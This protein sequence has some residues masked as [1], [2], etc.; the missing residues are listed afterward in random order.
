M[1]GM[2]VMGKTRM[3]LPFPICPSFT[4]PLSKPWRPIINGV[5]GRP[6]QRTSLGGKEQLQLNRLTD[7]STLLPRKIMT[8][9]IIDDVI[10]LGSIPAPSSFYGSFAYSAHIEKNP[11]DHSRITCHP[12]RLTQKATVIKR[13]TFK[14]ATSP[15]TKASRLSPAEDCGDVIHEGAFIRRPIDTRWAPTTTRWTTR[16]NRKNNPEAPGSG[17]EHSPLPLALSKAPFS[18]F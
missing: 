1:A 12:L 5:V 11:T 17:K 8:D 10:E 13:V 15:V 3:T 6:L 18:R 14:R 9:D 2:T 4:N 16:T 7:F